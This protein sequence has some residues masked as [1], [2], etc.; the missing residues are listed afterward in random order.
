MSIH[1][2]ADGVYNSARKLKRLAKEMYKRCKK[3]ERAKK[4]FHH[5]DPEKKGRAIKRYQTQLQ[6]LSPLIRE[7]SNTMAKSNEHLRELYKAFKK[8]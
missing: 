5:H 4:N 3:A 2:H 1:A 7:Y 6:K 8:H